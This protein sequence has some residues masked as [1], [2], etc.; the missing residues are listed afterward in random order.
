MSSFAKCRMRCTQSQRDSAGDWEREKCVMYQWQKRW[1]TTHKGECDRKRVYAQT[2]KRATKISATDSSASAS[3]SL[4]YL[5][6]YLQVFLPSFGSIHECKYSMQLPATVC[7]C[8]CMLSHLLLFL[9]RYLRSGLV[10]VVKYLTAN[11]TW[12]YAC[13]YIL[14]AWFR[15]QQIAACNVCEIKV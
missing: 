9:A 1:G 5:M 11:C 10:F 2:K 8:V 4:H 6:T 3:T 15:S 7:V 14:C 13:L 12:M